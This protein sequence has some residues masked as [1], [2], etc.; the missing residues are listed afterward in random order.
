M[1]SYLETLLQLATSSPQFPDRL[2]GVLDEGDFNDSIK[3]LE[4]EGSQKLVDYLDKVWSLRR[5][6]TAVR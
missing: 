2:C 4:D 3:D 6:R 1:D 5:T